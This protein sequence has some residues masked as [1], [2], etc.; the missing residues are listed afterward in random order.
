MF[1]VVHLDVRHG[2]VVRE[3]FKTGNSAKPT[4]MQLVSAVSLVVKV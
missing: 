4:E 3:Q 1:S 2:R